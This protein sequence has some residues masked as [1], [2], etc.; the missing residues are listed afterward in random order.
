M[1]GLPLPRSLRREIRPVS[2]GWPF[3]GGANRRLRLCQTS[4][5][6]ARNVDRHLEHSKDGDDAARPCRRDRR[7]RAVERAGRQ[8]R[9][10][11]GRQTGGQCRDHDDRNIQHIVQSVRIEH[12]RDSL[13][14]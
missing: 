10:A 4:H 1:R 7:G 12:G 2:C 14:G 9:A 11:V 3:R 8:R 5:A 13:K 6:I